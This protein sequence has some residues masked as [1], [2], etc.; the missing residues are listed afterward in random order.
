M[1]HI[2][3]TDD[4]EQQY[5]CRTVARSIGQQQQQPPAAPESAHALWSAPAATSIH[6]AVATAPFARSCSILVLD[7]L[8]VAPAAPSFDA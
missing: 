4:H 6:V 7:I 2:I 3:A 8:S 5:V 1:R